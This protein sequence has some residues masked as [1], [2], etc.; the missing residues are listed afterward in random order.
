M[1][2]ATVVTESSLTNSHNE[3]IRRAS[4]MTCRPLRWLGL[5][6]NELLGLTAI[7]SLDAHKDM[8]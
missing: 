4:D 8:I 7:M 3:T 5:I 2:T 6:I 1:V